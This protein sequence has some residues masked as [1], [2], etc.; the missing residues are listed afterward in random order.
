MSNSLEQEKQKIGQLE[1]EVEKQKQMLREKVDSLEQEQQKSEQLQHEVS[2]QKQMLQAKDAEIQS[3]E[4]R[5]DDS[6]DDSSRR[7]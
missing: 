5:L 4:H 3:L 2:K 6:G 7:G 1:Q